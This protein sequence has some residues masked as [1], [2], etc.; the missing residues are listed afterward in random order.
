MAIRGQESGPVTF[1]AGEAILAYER[2]KIESG[3][4]TNPPEVVAATANDR[5][6][7]YAQYGAADG[8]LVSVRVP[9]GTGYAIVNK[10]VS[11]GAPCY[12]GAAGKV[13]DTVTTAALLG[14]FM[15]AAAAVDD[16][17]TIYMFGAETPT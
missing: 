16:V 10:A 14:H 8:D 5:S 4:V 12:G 7:G 6:V 3:T 2:V 1:T 11:E 15:E 17:V 9:G 13:S